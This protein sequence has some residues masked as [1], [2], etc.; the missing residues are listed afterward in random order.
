MNFVALHNVKNDIKAFKYNNNNIKIKTKISRRKK[1]SRHE[2]AEKMK[3][4][5]V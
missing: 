2:K 3:R 4:H 1:R 5:N